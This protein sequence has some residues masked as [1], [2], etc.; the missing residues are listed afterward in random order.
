MYLEFLK[1]S[2][3]RFVFTKHDG[4][5][6]KNIGCRKNCNIKIGLANKILN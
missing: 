5:A 2:R 6:G 3:D 1:N 4:G